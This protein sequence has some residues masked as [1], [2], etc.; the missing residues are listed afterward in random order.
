MTDSP[1]SGLKDGLIL[2][3]ARMARGPYEGQVSDM[4]ISFESQKV[5]GVKGRLEV[6]RQT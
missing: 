4:E 6:A 5:I 1:V 2:A 3:E